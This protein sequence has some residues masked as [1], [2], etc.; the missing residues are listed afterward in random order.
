MIR[1]ILSDNLPEIEEL[2]LQHEVLDSEVNNPSY[3]NNS[4]KHLIQNS[5][6]LGHIDRAG[7][8]KEDT[9]F[10]EF[11]AGKGRLSV[12]DFSKYL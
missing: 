3:G 5:S 6:L 10:I 11:G 8:A 4:K 12:L 9:C 2:I 1:P 7:L